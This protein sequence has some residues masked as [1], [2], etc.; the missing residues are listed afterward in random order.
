MISNGCAAH[1]FISYN[2]DWWNQNVGGTRLC[3]TSHST[4]AA[5][6]GVLVLRLLMVGNSN[7]GPKQLTSHP[8]I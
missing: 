2:G 4:F 7:V 1:V 3:V 8:Q 6:T 5:C